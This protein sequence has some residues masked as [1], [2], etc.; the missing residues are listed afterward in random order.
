MGWWI[1][2]SLTNPQKKLESEK[3]SMVT[4]ADVFVF[5]G[6]LFFSKIFTMR[7]FF[8]AIL[9][10][11]RCWNFNRCV[12]LVEGLCLMGIEW[13]PTWL[14]TAHTGTEGHVTCMSFA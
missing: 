7:V 5:V 1:H 11:L 14:P 9:S 13:Y 6:T 10:S 2:P 12:F 8:F 3:K 4:F